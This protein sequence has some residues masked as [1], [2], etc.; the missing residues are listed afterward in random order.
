MQL[1]FATQGDHAELFPEPRIMAR[2][3]NFTRDRPTLWHTAFTCHINSL[4]H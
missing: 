1:E 3:S 2:C 4:T